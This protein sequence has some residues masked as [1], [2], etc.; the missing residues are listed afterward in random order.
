MKKNELFRGVDLIY[1]NTLATNKKTYSSTFDDLDRILPNG[2]WPRVGITEILIPTVNANALRLLL[3]A[4]AEISN[5][6]WVILVS[7]PYTPFSLAWAQAGA[8]VSK[9]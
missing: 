7:P 8:D 3:P 5:K 9:I 4:L 1:G 6:R 2:G